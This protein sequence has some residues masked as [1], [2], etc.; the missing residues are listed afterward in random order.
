MPM[1]TSPPPPLPPPTPPP[2]LQCRT[3]C[4][5]ERLPCDGPTIDGQDQNKTFRTRLVLTWLLSNA[6]LALTVQTLNGLDQTPALV[7][8][9]YPSTYSAYNSPQVLSLNGTC[10][11]EAVDQGA[12]GLEERQQVYFKYLLWVVFGLSAFRFLG[13]SYY[14]ASEAEASVCTIGSG[15]SYAGELSILSMAKLKLQMLSAHVGQD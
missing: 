5:D 9:C 10:I 11:L 15:D 8:A 2:L 3:F 13:V 12:V 4:R 14:G 6:A 7:R 1:V